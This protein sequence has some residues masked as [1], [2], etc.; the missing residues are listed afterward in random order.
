MC[1]FHVALIGIGGYGNH[2]VNTLLDAADSDVARIVSAV[3]PAPTA[4]RRLEELRSR[5][6][7]I[8]T[9]V[10]EL[11]GQD[12]I[13]L[14]VISTPIHLHAPHTCWAL[15]HGYHVLC[16]KPLCATLSEITQM[17]EARDT[18]QRQVAIG[19]QWSFSQAIHRLKNDIHSGRLGR[20][21][22][23][24]SI[25][26]WPRGEAYYNRNRWAGM[27]RSIEGNWVLDSPVNNA[28][29][30]H[31]HNM[32]YV[33]GPEPHLSAQPAQVTAELYRANPIDN[34]DT[35]ALRVITS[36]GTELLFY[37]T[38]AVQDTRGPEFVF[39][40]E[41]GTVHYCHSPHATLQAVFHDGT[42][43]DYGMPDEGRSQK[44][45]RTWNAIVNKTL[46][47]CGIEAASAH[48]RCVWAAQLSQPDIVM[49]P[50]DLIRTTGPADN[51]QTCVEGLERIFADCY[52]QAVLPSE[53]GV[54][55]TKRGRPIPMDQL[56]QMVNTLA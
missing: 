15:K 10:S 27:Q 31:L 30:H 18:A 36:E 16:E 55:W 20:P 38:H 35:A 39:E 47:P 41:R 4:C 51:R 28:C 56:V 24:R 6:V 44:L 14:A 1:P 46:V 19:Y 32:L 45:W 50:A 52:D 42:I 25:T 49:L 5:G 43:I 23:L 9:D 40:F 21:R 29:A 34:Y 2:Y 11:N 22:R 17:Q 26:L 13:D 3:D 54:P 33:L 53:L 48:T 12:R 8:Y 37:A 7:R